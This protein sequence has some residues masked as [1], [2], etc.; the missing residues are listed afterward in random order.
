MWSIVHTVIVVFKD[1]LQSLLGVGCITSRLFQSLKSL[2]HLLNL[3]VFIGLNPC[4]QLDHLVLV[5]PGTHFL[6][7]CLG[8]GGP[9]K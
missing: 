5:L 3:S 9:E 7:L 6:G 2:S 4:L 8:L 1:Q